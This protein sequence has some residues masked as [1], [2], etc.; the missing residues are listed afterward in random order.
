MMADYFTPLQDDAEL[1]QGDILRQ[2]KKPISREGVKWG[3]VINADCDLANRK[4]QGHISWLE[5]VPTE[6]YWRTFWAPQQLATFA[7]KKSQQLCDQIN[8][9]LRKQGSGLDNLSHDRLVDWV[10]RRK[11]QEIVSSIGV[12]NKNLL[13]ELT[14]F[15]MAV[16]ENAGSS[17][18]D[19]LEACQEYLG[20]STE[21]TAASFRQFITR[22]DGFPD[23]VL[24]PDV[25][26]GNAK[27]YVV[28]LRRINGARET[29]V[30]KTELDARLND[31]PE[32]LHRI[33]RFRD[34]IRFQIVQKMSFLYSRIGSSK[35]FE[36]ECSQ[37][38]DWTIEDRKA[39]K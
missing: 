11:P 9:I 24:V 21:K 33:G 27:G 36:V 29:E 30:F 14:V 37:V 13:K 8:S 22:Q 12:D 15:S 38:V 35:E 17:S 3:F 34:G 31:R 6:E 25:P 4:N 28:L 2:Y 23:F 7:Q 26:N 5:V 19:V 1:R 20:Q 18:L 32:A 39:R 10:R 16:C